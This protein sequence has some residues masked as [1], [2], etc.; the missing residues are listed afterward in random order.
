MTTPGKA[1]LHIF[2]RRFYA[3]VALAS[4]AV[5]AGMEWFMIKTGFYDK[6]VRIGIALVAPLQR[7]RA[8][9][10]HWTLTWYYRSVHRRVTVIEAERI[11]DVHTGVAPEFGKR[12][13]DPWAHHAERK[14]QERA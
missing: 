3:K 6:C 13:P 11:V 14:G 12:A 10:A 2:D 5:G 4:A 8:Q 7:A 1:P 9:N